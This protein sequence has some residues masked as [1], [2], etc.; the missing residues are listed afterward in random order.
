MNKFL[1]LEEDKPLHH[2]RHKRTNMTQYFE[3]D[4]RDGAA[5]IGKFMLVPELLTPCIINT[6]ELG[7]IK[8]PGSIIDV[9]SFWGVES[10]VKLEEH[11]KQIR[12]KTKNGTLIILSHQ[13]Y[14]PFIST[15]SRGKIGTLTIDCGKKT[16][17]PLGSLL[18]TEGDIL[19]S[20]LYIMEG[21]GIFE[22]NA[23]K[24]LEILF[25]L[26][27]RI[28]PDTAL[29]APNLAL[30]ENVAMLI[31]FGIDVLDDTRTVIAAY[32]DI[33]LINSGNFHLENL[34]EFPCRC[35]VC[36]HTKPAEIRNLPKNDRAKFLIA[37][38]RNALESELSLIRE[39]IRTGTLREYVEGQCRVRPWLTALLRLGDFEY[40]YL[41]EKVPAFRQN[42]L[43]VDTSEALSR[44]EVT[45]F[46]KR[47]NERYNPPD[48]DILLILPCAAKKPYST[49]QSHQ[50]F[51]L[52]LGK[53]RKFIHEVILTSPL[54]IVPREL[55]LTYPAAHYDTAVTGHWDEGEKNW[56]SGCLETYLSKYSYKKVIAHVDGAYKEICERVANKLEIEIIYTA[57]ENLV[58]TEA[59]S[60]LKN[61][62]ESFCTAGDFSKKSLNAEEKKKNIMKAIATYQFG[63]ASRLLFDEKVEKLVVKGHF[64]KYQLFVGKK[65][66]ATLV[67]QY[68][69]LALSLDGGELMSKNG[70]YVVNIDDFVPCNS[71]LAPGIL[72]ADPQIRPNDEVIVLGDRA[73][74]VG[75]SRMSGNEMT[76][77]NRGV[78]VD[79]RHVK[80][81]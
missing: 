63:E 36:A 19:R 80:R 12:E 69:M 20:D 24:F 39:R 46:A 72:N 60:N 11:I 1:K 42:Q 43:L 2:N 67:P 47:V 17:G 71:V 31:Y 66:F 76:K 58:S 8:N 52:A 54:G 23:R 5:R 45:R 64:P 59:L 68:G 16:E 30:P 78:A 29:Y 81:L 7:N 77:S 26:K 50:K 27:D 61:I 74:C 65:Q 51:I 6:S 32:S 13:V 41:E 44:I 25:K 75:R 28:L 33:Y 4:K 79:I 21:A 35:R 37:H 49:S 9:G 70:K 53:Y 38:N 48:L 3:I 18:R 55:E 10:N 40:Y 56:V 34:T 57:K 62:V 22:N 14:P 73:L 15:E